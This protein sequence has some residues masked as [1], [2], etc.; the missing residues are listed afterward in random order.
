MRWRPVEAGTGQAYSREM[1][2][3]G[4]QVFLAGGD[5]QRCAGIAH[6]VSERYVVT[7]GQVSSAEVGVVQI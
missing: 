1:P 5:S 7:G 6:V 2:R 3:L 4:D